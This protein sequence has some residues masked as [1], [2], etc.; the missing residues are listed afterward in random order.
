MTKRLAT[1]PTN[2]RSVMNGALMTSISADE[3][4]N[5]TTIILKCYFKMLVTAGGRQL[6]EDNISAFFVLNCPI[7]AESDSSTNAWR[8]RLVTISAFPR[9]FNIRRN[10]RGYQILLFSMIY[11]YVDHQ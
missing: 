10:F 2:I 4:S 9:K 8:Q 6:Q 1:S 5:P 3:K 11:L 7:T